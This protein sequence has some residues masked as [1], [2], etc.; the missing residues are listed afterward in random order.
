ILAIRFIVLVA[1]TDQVIECKPVMTGHKINAID[2]LLSGVLINIRAPGE[3]GSEN[4]SHSPISSPI[5]T[6]IVPVPPIPF[7]P[8]PARETP[9]L[10]GPPRV[11]GLGNQFDIPQ[12]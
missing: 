8:A 6:H 1:V 4:P 5:A 10:I 2:R 12:N 11:P 7:R 9:H 3:S